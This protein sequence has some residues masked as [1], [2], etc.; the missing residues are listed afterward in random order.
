[1]AKIKL[2]DS[3]ARRHLLEGKL[4]AKKARA[5]AD[6]YL[7]QGREIEAIDFLSHAEATD[8][9]GQL[10]KAALERGDV[11]LMK[12]AS[13]ALGDEP[14]SQTWRDLATAATAKGRERDA[15]SAARLATVEA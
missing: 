15:E 12:A 9:L 4:D 2:P 1:M 5:I 14:S 8:E 10:Q 3:L 11:F 6:A 13:A 7:E